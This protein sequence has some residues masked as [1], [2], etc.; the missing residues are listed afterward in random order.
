MFVTYL[1]II[2]A[3]LTLA[4]VAAGSAVI[5]RIFDRQIKPTIEAQKT[6]AKL[7][8]M[9]LVAPRFD[10]GLREYDTATKLIRSGDVPNALVHLKEIISRYKDSARYRDAK[11]ILG[12]H[13]V[14]ILLSRDPMKGKIDYIVERGDSLSRISSRNKTTIEYI[15]QVN[16]RMGLNLQ[17]GEQ[18]IVTPLDFRVV[19]HSKSRMLEL[20]K[21]DAF[22]KEYPLEGIKLPPGTSGSFDSSV[23]SKGAYVG[24]KSVRIGDPDYVEAEKVINLSRNGV[25]IRH[26]SGES[27]EDEFFTGIFLSREDMEELLV[28]LR[29]G[30]KVNIRPT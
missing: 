15:L 4:I 28:L 1:K 23:R 8:E 7:E 26:R 10:L 13:N 2:A 25:S 18:L 19:I 30:M 16:N 21:D 24:S 17:P 29:N 27:V 12:E 22:F 11:R 5:Y 3:F 20:R 14:D 9:R 6:I